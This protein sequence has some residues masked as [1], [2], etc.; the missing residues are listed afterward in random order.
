MLSIKQIFISAFIGRL[1]VNFNN[2]ILPNFLLKENAV[3]FLFQEK[4][5]YIQ[6]E[7][8]LINFVKNIEF[9]NKLHNSY[10]KKILKNMNYLNSKSTN[11]INNS[12]KMIFNLIDNYKN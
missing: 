11:F 12:A 5:N 3:P 10:S 6:M 7:K 4:C 9:Q 8:V 2:V 1:L